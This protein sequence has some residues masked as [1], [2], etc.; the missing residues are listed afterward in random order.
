MAQPKT[1][2]FVEFLS[3]I[4]VDKTALIAMSA[5]EEQARLAARNVENIE[6]CKAESLNAFQMLNNKYLVIGKAELEA[7]LKGPS[8]QTGKDAKT[9]PMGAGP[10]V[11]A[12]PK[13]AKAPKAEKPAKTAKSPAPKSGAKKEAK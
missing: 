11:P 7:W 13:A 12:A 3:N 10:V 9:A 2:A 1:S 6:L 5:K 8:S 4:K